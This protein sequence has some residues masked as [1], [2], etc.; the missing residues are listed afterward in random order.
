MGEALD[1]HE[2]WVNHEVDTFEEATSHIPEGISQGE[3]LLSGEGFH[4]SGGGSML[5]PGNFPRL[6]W[7]WPTA[8]RRGPLSLGW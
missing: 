8:P 4:H 7:P 5:R 3:G 2:P 1:D 6:W